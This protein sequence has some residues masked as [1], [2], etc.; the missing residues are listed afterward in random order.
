MM[1]VSDAIIS[2]VAV[3][4]LL[5]T[6]VMLDDRVRDQVSYRLLSHPSEQLSN[7]GLQV[8][9]LTTVIVEAT[10]DQTVAHAQM[11]GFVL[12]GVVLFLFMTRT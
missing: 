10:A 3:L 11:M 6:L 4:L 9:D 5:A 2:V 1:R 12:A 8:R 7:A